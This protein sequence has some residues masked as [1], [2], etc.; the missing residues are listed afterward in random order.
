M[1]DSG[2]GEAPQSSLWVRGRRATPACP[3]TGPQAL[4]THTVQAG[5]REQTSGDQTKP[6]ANSFWGGWG[7]GYEAGGVGMGR[8]GGSLMWRAAV[9]REG[10]PDLEG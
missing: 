5:D 7:R 9:P 1:E 4:A 6:Q 3:C 2:R 8:Q 10:N